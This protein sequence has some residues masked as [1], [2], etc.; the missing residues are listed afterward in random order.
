[1]VHPC[2]R[3]RENRKCRWNWTPNN[4]AKN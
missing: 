2:R 4:Q 1:M 3:T